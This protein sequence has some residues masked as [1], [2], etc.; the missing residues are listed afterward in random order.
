MCVLGSS[1]SPRDRALLLSSKF[2]KFEEKFKAQDDN[3][4]ELAKSGA[5]ELLLNTFQVAVLKDL[6]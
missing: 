4:P 6:K 3:P 2:E 1:S 5:R